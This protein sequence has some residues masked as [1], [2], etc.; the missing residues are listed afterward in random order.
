MILSLLREDVPRFV[1]FAYGQ[2][3]DP[4][5]ASVV[6]EPGPFFQMPTNYVITGEYVTKTLIHLETMVE[7]DPMTGQPVT[8]IVTVKEN[9]NEVPPTE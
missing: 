2:S 6:T 4:A 7:P 9:Y 3:L 5:P 1:V 8:R